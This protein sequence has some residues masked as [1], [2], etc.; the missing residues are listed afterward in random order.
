MSSFRVDL[1]A[2]PG[3]DLGGAGE[4]VF[5]KRQA[6]GTW[7][8]GVFN[9]DTSAPRTLSVP[10]GFTGS[11]S[12][13]RVTD[14]WTGRSLGILSGRYTVTIAPGGVSLISARAASLACVLL[15]SR[16]CTAFCTACVPRP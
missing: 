14:L 16:L 5:A 10:L 4:Q 15:V 6:D 9:T 11:S 13:V 1:G 7:Y 12:R 2:D 8:I 3:G